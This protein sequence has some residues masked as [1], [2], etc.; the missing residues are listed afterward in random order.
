MYKIYTKINTRGKE[1]QWAVLPERKLDGDYM[2]ILVISDTHRKTVRAV[3]LLNEF[4]K[5]VDAVIHL[6]DNVEDAD[7]IKRNYKL[8]VY[9]VAGNCDNIDGNVPQ[10]VLLHAGG[11][12]IFFTHGHY[13]DVKYNINTIAKRAAEVKADICLYGHTHKPNLQIQDGIIFFN[14]GSLS[15][16]RG[17]SKPSYGIVKIDGD[18]IYPMVMPYI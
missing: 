9:V 18:N 16:P 11:K 5:K 15:E 14:P 8:P 12:R 17:D 3:E 13:Y 7:F 6:G 4:S 10:E 2:R 1:R